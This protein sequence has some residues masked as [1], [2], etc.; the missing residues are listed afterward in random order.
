[1]SAD[2]VGTGPA[3]PGDVPRI[4]LA[5]SGGGSRAAAFHLGCLRALHDHD[6]L[7]A[8]RVVSG[9]SGGALLAAL[10]AY[11]P[12]EFAAF[13]ANVSAVLRR[14][15][16]GPILRRALAPTSLLRGAA[17]AARA[18]RAHSPEQ[19]VRTWNRTEAFAQLLDS[20]LF[21]RADLTSP[22]HAGLD[23]VLSATDLRCGAAV[24]FGS[25]ASGC[26]RY[27]R[28]VEPVTVGTAVAA[29]AAYPVMLPALERRFTFQ[30]GD[31]TRHETVL[32]ADG[33]LMDNLGLSVLTPGRS[34]AHTAH[35]YDVD[36][37]VSCDA[38]RGPLALRSPRFLI[39]RNVRAF[40][41]TH[42]QA[43]NS[44]R[45]RLHEWGRASD[46]AG[47]VMAYLGMRDENLPVPVADL[48]PRHAVDQYPTNFD[49][50]S[51]ADLEALSIRGEQL[52]RTLLPYYT[53]WLC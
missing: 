32:L 14:G 33:G 45:G 42:A 23:V 10:W 26:S 22:T 17:S 6:L 34:A 5:L 52:I 12:R 28:I 49:A 30:R 3:E 53:P 2:T 51:T 47:F 18:L 35:V 43:Q 9:I 44:A 16:S 38:G 1:M 25:A 41:V 50:M 13:D 15:L 7:G 27:G 24:R 4:G 20:D 19:P 36:V 37:I 31:T 8:V 21:D 29:S 39:G 48:V 46:I 11:G 40:E